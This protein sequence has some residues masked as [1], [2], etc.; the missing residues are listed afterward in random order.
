MMRRLSIAMLL[1]SA[2]VA[3]GA[4]PTDQDIDAAL[5]AY[6]EAQNGDRASPEYRKKL[7]DAAEAEVAKL[8]IA[9]MSV[10]QFERVRQILA[11]VPAKRDA[12]SA[13]L[14]ELAKE[15]TADGAV[16]SVMQMSMAPRGKDANETKQLQREAIAGVLE[17]PGYAAALKEGRGGEVLGMMG[18]HNWGDWKG[19]NVPK[20]VDT[21]LAGDIAPKAITG[22]AGLF[23]AIAK[24]E[25]VDKETREHMRVK[26]LAALDRSIKSA[27]PEDE[28]VKTY[29]QRTASYLDGPFAKGTLLNNPSPEINFTWVSGDRSDLKTVADLKGKVVVLDFWATWCGPCIAS[30]PNVRQLAE[31]YQGYPVEIVG[32]TSIQGSHYKRT[33]D[34]NKSE[35]IDCAN[36]TAKELGLMPEFMKDMNMTWTVAFSTQDVFNPDYGVRGIPHVAILDPKGVVRFRGL[37]PGTELSEK[38]HKINELLKE[39]GL[40]F[41]AD[42][43]APEKK[44]SN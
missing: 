13:R 24:D 5:K 15:P 31:H 22:V 37:H 14:A 12:V 2:G 17:H 9:E 25:A 6:M 43:A 38:Y 4:P 27:K 39:A 29:L 36:D 11:M 40:P 1:A 21:L 16:A 19:T 30:F 44:G 20:R 3:F 33:L 32:V 41:P 8:D 28:K 26:M 42:E 7:T 10:P 18:Q 23:D 34:S 35:K